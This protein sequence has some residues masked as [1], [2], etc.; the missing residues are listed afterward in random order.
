MTSRVI[1]E[2]E[3]SLN[4][5]RY[6]LGGDGKV[7]TVV[8]SQYPQKLVLGDVDKDS[9][10]RTSII[11]WDDWTGGI[12]LYSTNGKEGMNRSSFSRADGRYKGHLILPPIN[13]SSAD[14]SVS[15]YQG[16]MG[17]LGDKIYVTLNGGQDIYAYNPADN[18]WSG[19][20]HSLTVGAALTSLNFR[21]GG[22]QYLAFVNGATGGTTH[23]GFA[24]ATSAD[25]TSWTNE[26]KD[27]VSLA[28]WDNRLWGISSGG[29]LWFATTIG[30]Q[31]DDALISK[32][33]YAYAIT[34]FVGP[35]AS[36]EEILYCATREGLYAHD[37]ANARFVRTKVQWP[38]RN[39]VAGAFTNYAQAAATWNGDIYVSPGGMT[40]YRY[41]PTQGIVVSMGLDL[42]A[43]ITDTDLRG[44]NITALIPTFTGLLAIVNA[45]TTDSVWE[46]NGI[47]WH[48]FTE[49]YVS[50][51]AGSHHISA[52]SSYYRFYH[53][54]GTGSTGGILGYVTLKTGSVN[55]DVDTTISYEGT[56]DVAIHET[57]W[58]NAGQNEI[59]KTAIRLRIECTGMTDDETVK[60]EYALNYSGTYESASTSD[61]KSTFTVKGTASNKV[62]IAVFPKV[63]TTATLPLANTTSQAGSDFQAIRFK[64]TLN[65]GSTATLTPNMKSLSLEWRRKIPARYGF[66]FAIDRSQSYGGRTPKEMK[67]HLITAVENSAQ[68]EF[69]FVDDDGSTQNYYV[70]VTNM[71]DVEDTGHGEIGQT[72]IAVVEA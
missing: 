51:G 10:P 32:Q 16:A 40:V 70:D 6:P 43:G 31:V 46:Y 47:G 33:S 65:R 34:L 55:P 49:T 54:L 26:A 35:D 25:G 14:P 66:E 29:Q 69:T 36:G 45:N 18:T 11:V 17:D 44:D 52:S 1:V 23:E 72:R 67:S 57:P 19:S 62:T 13:A 15:G 58:F 37:A 28:F 59:D 5:K 42:D 2:R 20:H 8:A 30:T 56:N 38:Y 21:L 61:G 64:L 7:R 22:T 60:V 27:T 9:N 50:T 63:G 41:S 39:V 71:E 53:A 4:G 12:G 3:I 48:Y 24:W 68:V